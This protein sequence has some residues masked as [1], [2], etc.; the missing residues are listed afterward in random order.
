MKWMPLGEQRNH[1][2]LTQGMAAAT[3]V[4]LV[5]AWDE[6]R[7]TPEGHAEMI[8]RCRGCAEPEAC[9]RLLDR[10]AT[11][12]TPPDYCRNTAALSQLRDD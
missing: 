9:R 8:T 2:W 7:L 6:G 10:I 3:G 5:K 11:L 4:S 1:Y 12:E